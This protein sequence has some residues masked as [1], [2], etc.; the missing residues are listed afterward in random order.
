M[1]F[2]SVEGLDFSYGPHRV[3]KDIDLEI[4]QGQVVS[5]VGRNGAGKTTLLK[6]INRIRRYQHGRVRLEGKDITAMSAPE[7]AAC[8]GYVP[9]SSSSNFPALVFDM[10]MLGRLPQLTWKVGEED[11]RVVSE[12]IKRMNLEDLAFRSFNQLS[13]GERQRVLIARALAQGPR[14]LLLDEPTSSLDIMNQLEV[15]D[16]VREAADGGGMTAVVSIHDLNLAA[17]YSDEVVVIHEGRIFDHGP[18]E[19][20]IDEDMVMEVYGIR[21]RIARDGESGCVTVTPI[22]VHRQARS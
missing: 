16:V 19:D 10:V 15:L 1:T 7:L 9:Q 5:L 17:R 14:M 21:S 18:P 4:G 11:L 12:V 22:G 20:V 8:F 3:L 2:F 13:G 6:C